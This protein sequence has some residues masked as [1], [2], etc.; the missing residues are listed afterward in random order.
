MIKIAAYDQY[1]AEMDALKGGLR[2]AVPYGLASEH[3]IQ[4]PAVSLLWGRPGAMGAVAKNTGKSYLPQAIG[5]GA[6]GGGIGGSV[7]GILQALA[8]RNP[9]AIPA[10]VA[11]GVVGGAMVA[12]LAYGGGH[13]FGR[14]QKKSDYKPKKS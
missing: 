13:I 10:N 11:A 4:H 7:Y 9:L 3:F 14:P 2:G 5:Q 8:Q 1:G 12:P 6:V